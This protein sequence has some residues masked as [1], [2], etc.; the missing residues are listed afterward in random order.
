M[1]LLIPLTVLKL[2]AERFPVGF[3]ESCMASGTVEGDALLIGVKDYD[4]AKQ[5]PKKLMRQS[6]KA[7]ACC[8]GKPK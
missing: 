7:Q 3:L 1:N 5:R 4:K 6:V 8:G 2:K